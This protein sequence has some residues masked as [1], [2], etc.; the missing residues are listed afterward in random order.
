VN[1][2]SLGGGQEDLKPDLQIANPS[3][4]TSLEQIDPIEHTNG[5]PKKEASIVH[6]DEELPE[7]L[8]PQSLLRMLGTFLG[9]SMNLRPMYLAC[10]VGSL[11]GGMLPQ[12]NVDFNQL[13]TI[14]QGAVYPAQALLLTR[15][16][17]AFELPD[18]EIQAEVNFFALI[19]FIVAIV[20]L[21]VY[22]CIGWVTNSISQVNPIIV[23]SAA[24]LVGMDH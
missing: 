19:F 17:V 15:L 1:A 22:A 9:E 23:R 7:Q 12:S 5:T 11:I 3:K 14:F 16:I 2:Q 8:R 6:H 20:L 18:D 21:L 10:F 4:Q 24:N 13:T